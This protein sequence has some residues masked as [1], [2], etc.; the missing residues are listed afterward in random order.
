[1]FKFTS[2]FDATNSDC[3]GEQ[4]VIVNIR[5][6]IIWREGS[7]PNSDFLKR[8]KKVAQSVVLRFQLVAYFF[9][10]SFQNLYAAF[11][12]IKLPS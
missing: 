1:M 9:F 11:S 10:L 2:A 8:I 7:I 3:Q 5:V 6:H 12:I 4:V